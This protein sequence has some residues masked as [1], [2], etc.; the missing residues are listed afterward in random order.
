MVFL[1]TPQMWP[2]ERSR[3]CQ[4]NV[5][6]RHENRRC[7]PG[8]N[9]RW[10]KRRSRDNQLEDNHLRSKRRKV[11][12]YQ[13][14]WERWE[15]VRCDRNLNRVWGCEWWAISHTICP[16]TKMEKGAN[17]FSKEV[18]DRKSKECET[19]RRVGDSDFIWDILRNRKVKRVKEEGSRKDFQGVTVNCCW[20]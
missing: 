17:W 6:W 7:F 18:G 15:S 2:M 12:I 3:C 5:R 1:K 8:K 13:R 4:N 20:I 10:E 14:A 11:S 16:S 19:G 9:A